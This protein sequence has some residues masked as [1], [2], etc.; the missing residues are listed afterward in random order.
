MFVGMLVFAAIIKLPDPV[1]VGCSWPVPAIVLWE[2][3]YWS[4]AS[5][6]AA[7]PVPRTATSSRS[8]PR[9][10][11]ERA[12][13]VAVVSVGDE[14]LVG[15]HPEWY[16]PFLASRMALHGRGGRRILVVGDD[17]ADI[18]EAVCS[19]R[20]RRGSCSSRAAWARPWTT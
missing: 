8:P 17:E 6:G 12:E 13:L 9:M 1:T 19:P 3:G 16:G 10:S 4:R 7:T 2:I 15:A 14:L 11:L 18:A 5:S 20:A